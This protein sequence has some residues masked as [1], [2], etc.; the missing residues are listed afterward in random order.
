M[1]T[2]HRFLA[3]AL[4]TVCSAAFAQGPVIGP[5]LRIDVNG[6][7]A[8]ANENSAASSRAGQDIIGSWNDWRAGSQQNEIIRVGAAVSSDGGQTWNDFTVRPPASNQ[9]SVE[10][11]PMTA[12][13][14]RTGTVWVGGISFAGNGGLFVAKKTPGQ[15]TFGPSVMARATGG[16]D[17]CWMA[18]GPGP[19]DPT[20]TSFYIAYNEGVIRS[21]D[22]GQT[23]SAPVAL[24][25]GIGFNPRVGPN[26][27]L[28]V[29]YWDFSTGVMLRRSFNG[30]VSFDPAIRIATR[31]D[32]WGTQD[33][34]RFPGQFRVP[35]MNA[36]A[37]DPTDGTLYC[38]YFDKT[39]QQSNGAN[40]DLYFTKSTD[41]GSTWSTPKVINR[42]ATTPGDQFFPWVEV[43]ATG[44]LHVS[45]WDSRNVVQN[46]GAVNGMFDQYYTYSDDKGQTWNE[47][48]LT[49]SSWNSNNDGLNRSNQF[50]G[51]YNALAYGGDRAYPVYTS[52]Q[53]G[54]PDTFTH[55]IEDIGTRTEALNVVFGFVQSGDVASV[56]RSDDVWL[57]VLNGPVPG[58]TF[59]PVTVEFLG[60]SASQTAS[61]LQFL[62]EN[63]VTINGL[64]QAVDLFDYSA[65][66]YVEVDARPATTTDSF[67]VVSPSNPGR[68]IES[69]TGKVRARLRV[70][71]GGVVISNA[72][73]SLIDK[74]Y[75]R[76]TP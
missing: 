55:V 29:A 30:G 64:N 3:A 49:P 38:I 1:R 66:A 17:K 24:G 35:P 54:N 59:S 39:N 15:N 9:T 52:T 37:V 5:Q 69:A 6:G 51:D 44:R 19:N 74:A 32:T 13:D 61:K 27:E 10:G 26:G 56:Q 58:N 7:A 76:I 28:Y 34:S 71:P 48:R 12:Y 20:K 33:G 73:R 18:A 11:D 65:G 8:A 40:I 60:T 43:D 45:F 47:T 63:R 4:L 46:D 50:M 70:R 23:W 21:T 36:L 72:W 16:A 75:W 22:M 42:D 14:N 31:M 41:K 25:S 53:N 2:K 68:F 67:V 62:I 57:D